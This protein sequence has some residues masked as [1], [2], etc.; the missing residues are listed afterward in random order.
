DE[1]KPDIAAPGSGIRSSVPGGGYASFSGTSMAAPAVSGVIALL[2]EAGG[3]SGG[4]EEQVDQIEE[5]LT[6][7]ARE[8][9]D[10]EYPD[11]PNNG[12]GHGIVDAFAAVTSVSDGL[13]TI[14]GHVT[15]EGEDTTPPEYNHTP[16][17][18]MLDGYDLNLSIEASDDVAVT[19]VELVYD[20]NTVDADLVS[21]NVKNG[22]YE[23]V[24]PSEDITGDSFTYHWV[25]ND[26]GN[27]EVVTDE[28]TIEITEPI[29]FENFDE[30]P[31]WGVFVGGADSSWEWGVPTSGPGSAKTGENVYATNLSGN[32]YGDEFSWLEMPALSIREGSAFIEIEH[33]FDVDPTFA[34][35]VLVVG[36]D[37]NEDYQVLDIFSGESG[38]WV[39]GIYDISDFTGDDIYIAFVLETI[40]FGD[41]DGWYIDNVMVTDLPIGTSSTDGKSQV[42]EE[43]GLPLDATVSVLESNR[44][45]NTDP[46]NGSYSI[47]HSPGDLTVVAE[48]YGFASEER[49]VTLP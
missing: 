30:D 15:Q 33:W 17:N 43:E 41:R 14:T 27:N 37:P 21:G 20:G 34:Q 12:Y 49:S 46:A 18:G 48:S 5:I 19:S 31:E 25:I 7:T 10:S 29:L 42:M 35:A 28:Y 13:G 16:P 22:E 24:V 8:R 39:E 44:S 32:Y 26:Y 6:A 2:I 3:F 36:N 47:L 9:T 38:G 11:S 45:V 1:I 23:A 4:L 40:L